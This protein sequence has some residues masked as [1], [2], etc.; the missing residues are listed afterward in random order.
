[1]PSEA[2]TASNALVNFVSRSGDQEAERLDPLPHVVHQVAGLLCG[3][4]PGWVRGDTEDV[5]PPGGD[6]HH[7]QHVQP[8]QGDRVE[9]E[10]VDS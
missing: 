2:N 1:M 5:H 3:P 9:I 7:E 6:L 4:R 8:A 10:E